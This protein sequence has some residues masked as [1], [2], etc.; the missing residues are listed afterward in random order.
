MDF[1]DYAG[2][3]RKSISNPLPPLISLMIYHK[4]LKEYGFDVPFDFVRKLNIKDVQRL[5]IFMSNISPEDI[6]MSALADKALILSSFGS[7]TVNVN[8]KPAVP[9]PR[10]SVRS[11][12][13]K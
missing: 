13:F 11:P 10:G 2:G 12:T 4:R 1:K 5:L 6:N 7:S 9:V 8:A 3:K